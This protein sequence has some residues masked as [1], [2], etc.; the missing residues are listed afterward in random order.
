MSN[1]LPSP[2][3]RQLLLLVLSIVYAGLH[4][5]TAQTAGQQLWSQAVVHDVYL[6]FHQ[7]SY[8]DTLST[9]YTADV[10][11]V[12]DLTIDGQVLSNS[13]AKYKGNSSYNNPG[14]KKSFKLDLNEFVAGQEYDGIKKFNLNNGFK[15]PS[16]LREKL[17]LDFLVAHGIAAPRCSYARV[18]VNGNYWGLYTL[19]EEVNNDFCDRWF[20]SS[21]GN[22]FK[23]D[24]S[25]DLRWYGSSPNLYYNRYELDNNETA[26]DWSDL[27]R[28][29]DKINN[30]GTSFHDSLAEV[31]NTWPFFRHWAADNLF[32]NLDSYIG[33]GHNYFI[34]HESVS[35]RF[36][37]VHWDV[38]EAFGNFQQQL[39]LAQIK[40]LSWDYI[41]NA[42]GR[43]LCQRVLGD[44]GYRSDY[45][46]A[47]CLLSEDFSNNYFDPIIDSIVPIIRPFVYAD[48]MKT[49]S[50]QQFED[51]VVSDISIT[52]PMGTQWIAGIKSFIR[53][54]GI[55]IRNQLSSLGCT[56]GIDNSTPA[57][58]SPRLFPNPA[59]STTFIR[60]EQPLANPTRVEML[61]LSGKMIHLFQVQAGISEYVISLDDLPA[62]VYLLRLGSEGTA[63]TCRPL[64]ITR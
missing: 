55:S 52:S 54:R 11:T 49:F 23:G 16:F 32:A 5:A 4:L 43:P 29:I 39:S 34:Y 6:Q 18:Y 12:C 26:N 41:S 30:S 17:M 7:L 19:V 21:S 14:P 25:G 63:P 47:L 15:D 48:S 3:M 64:M 10:Y 60:W 50:N 13:G 1:G 45:I 53:D 46:Q 2:A 57:N 31:L 44:P 22:R 59:N 58:S 9:N 28:L 56:V 40:S 20:G 33:S 42:T 8:L 62:G 24:P 27:I 36:E 61:D 38:N 51:N 35:D 37:W